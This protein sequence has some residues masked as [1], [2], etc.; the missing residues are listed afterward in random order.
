MLASEGTESQGGWPLPSRASS[1]G[2]GET[3]GETVAAEGRASCPV[4]QGAWTQ[5]PLRMV[6]EG[7]RGRNIWPGP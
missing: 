1:L 6:R 5:L 7:I 3:P 4:C 2:E